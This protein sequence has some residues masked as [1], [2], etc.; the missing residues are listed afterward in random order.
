MSVIIRSN[1]A[2]PLVGV[3]T[4]CFMWHWRVIVLKFNP[5]LSELK[6]PAAIIAVHGLSDFNLSLGARNSQHPVL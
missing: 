4:I 2:L 5:L 6:S 3:F 1:T